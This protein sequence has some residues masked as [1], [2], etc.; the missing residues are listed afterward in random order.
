M[1]TRAAK[2]FAQSAVCLLS[3]TLVAVPTAGD[4]LARNLRRRRLE[5]GL[6]VSELARSAGVSKATISAVERGLGNP[7]VDT[8]WALAQALNVSFGALFDDDG[9]DAIQLRRLDDAPVVS[10]APG[11]V[12]RQLLTLRRGGELEVY[13]LDVEAAAR[14]DAAP[15]SAGVIEHV[16]VIEGRIETGPAG[17]SSVLGPGDCL[18]FPAD[19]PHVYHG[20]EK[21][22][23]LS[24]TDYPA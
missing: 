5:R 15:H 23:L 9:R 16:V 1:A 12:G 10:S 8:V 6:S 20:R 13:V 22:R 11:F 7:S 3:W 14:R 4:A 17:S 24:L 18:T 19:G 2:P 21:T